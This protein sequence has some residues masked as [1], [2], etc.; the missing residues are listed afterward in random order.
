MQTNCIFH[1]VFTILP[2][3]DN[4]FPKTSWDSIERANDISLSKFSVPKDMLKDF[5][6]FAQLQGM[7]CAMMAKDDGSIWY[8]DAEGFHRTTL[9]LNDFLIEA[10][11]ELY[12]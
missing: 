12:E 6:I 5:V 1:E 11:K 4:R 2:I 9:N 8:E 3:C 7:T 10:S